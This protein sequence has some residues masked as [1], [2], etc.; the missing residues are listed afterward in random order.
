MSKREPTA[1]DA[2]S[3]VPA[4]PEGHPDRERAVLICE[5][6]SSTLSLIPFSRIQEMLDRAIAE[7]L[8]IPAL[9]L[10]DLPDAPRIS[11]E[12]HREVVDRETEKMKRRF[13]GKHR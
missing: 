1:L 8:M 3:L 12:S 2:V 7:G 10:R 11:A 6:V 4:V 5:D 13:Y 9:V